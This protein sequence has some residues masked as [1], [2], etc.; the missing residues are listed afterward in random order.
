[1]KKSFS[2]AVIGGGASGLL[3]AVE[4][5]R[6]KNALNGREI[7]ILEKLDRVGKKLIATGNG[8]GNLAN[9]NFGEEFYHGDKDFI[10]S[11]VR[12]AREIDV[13][14][15]FTDLGIPFFTDDKGKKYPLSRQASS[16]LD[17]IR[18][19]LSKN[20][21][22]VYNGFCVEKITESGK[23]FVLESANGSISAKK[24]VLACGGSAG[25]Q[26][27][28]DGASYKL[29]ERFGHKKTELYPSLVQIKTELDKIRGLKGIKEYARVYALD[30]ERVLKSQKGDI[31]FTEY[32]L[33]GNTVFS[34]SGYLAT[35]KKP[36]IRIEFLP[37]YSFEETLKILSDRAKKTE[38]K[39]CGV[40]C[41]IVNKKVGE[42][43]VKIIDSDN[44][45]KLAF[46]LK[47]FKLSV[48]GNMGFNY[49]QVTKG[50]VITKDVNATTFESKLK[51][52]FYLTGEVLNVD[53][54]CGGYNLTFAFVSAICAA[55]SIKESL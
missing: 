39:E 42:K 30:G 5:L 23:S 29:A 20:G 46:A 35:A 1:M 4:L 54:D 25:K 24:V 3:C 22:N 36:I 15:Y 49:A 9:E 19:I 45:Q 41:G 43:L 40:L 17:I 13:E 14:R 31:L 8:A 38:L 32:G 21:V 7:V 16:V 33:S 26:F 55:K 50:G 11:F 47:N 52:G 51:S 27:G 48:T 53:G 2:V 10:K 37:D 18:E 44:P 34:V 12:L 28:T 6:G